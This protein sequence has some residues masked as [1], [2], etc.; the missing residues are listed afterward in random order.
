MLLFLPT[1]ALQMKKKEDKSE[2]HL[3]V[4]GPKHVTMTSVTKLTLKIVQD[5]MLRS[6]TVKE[7]EMVSFFRKNK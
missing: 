7:E 6:L 5:I 2:Q 4:K 3:N 1:D